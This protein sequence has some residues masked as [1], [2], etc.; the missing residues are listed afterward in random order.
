MLS[1]IPAASAAATLLLRRNAGNRSQHGPARGGSAGAS[2]GMV[3]RREN[4]EIVI[5]S[6][7]LPVDI[8]SVTGRCQRCWSHAKRKGESEDKMFSFPAFHLAALRLCVR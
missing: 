2:P 1:R 4:G 5:F 3:K 7:C 8:S 6:L